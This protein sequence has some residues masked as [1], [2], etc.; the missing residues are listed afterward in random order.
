MEA[1]KDDLIFVGLN[2]YTKRVSYAQT[3]NMRKKLK[4]ANTKLSKL[5]E[6]K[7]YL[8]KFKPV[9]S[10][11]LYEWNLSWIEGYLNQE[12]RNQREQLKNIS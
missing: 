1:T 3:M 4:E 8:L 5:G 7:V 11:N 10:A 2:N 9:G 12:K 6:K